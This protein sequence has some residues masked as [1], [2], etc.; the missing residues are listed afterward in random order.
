MENARGSSAIDRTASNH[1]DAKEKTKKIK[2]LIKTGK[3]DADVVKYIPGTLEMVYR[4][5]LE[6]IDTRE[7]V[8]GTT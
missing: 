1:N 7:K 4:A 6:D 8:H 3:Y 2:E 5:M